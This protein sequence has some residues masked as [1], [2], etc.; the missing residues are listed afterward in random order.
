ML[1]N[2]VAWRRRLSQSGEGPTL[3]PVTTRAMY[4]GQSAGLS[5]FTSGSAAA[6]SA[7]RAGAGF[8]PAPRAEAIS[9]AIPT[10]HMQSVRFAVI[11]TS[12]T[13]SADPTTEASGTPT[14]GLPGRTQIPCDSSLSPSSRSEQ[15]IPCDSTPRILVLRSFVPSGRRLPT[16]AT[17][18]RCPAATFGAPQTIERRA[19]PMSTVQRLSRSASGCRATS[20]TLPTTIP[21]S[22]DAPRSSDWTGSPRIASR[23][24]RSSGRSG[25][26][27]QSSSHF[28]VIFTR[29]PQN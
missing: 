23:L 11:S 18:T 14:G 1:R 3:S 28:H 8:S 20:S 24:A 2:P 17:A 25:R 5:I 16:C 15:I 10:T 21:G 22:K 9:L 19:V 27:T 6:P 4:R 26:S 13:G 29:S 7:R 12:I